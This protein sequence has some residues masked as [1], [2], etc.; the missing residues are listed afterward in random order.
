MASYCI[1]CDKEKSTNRGGFCPYCMVYTETYS[2][3]QSRIDVETYGKGL[4]KPHSKTKKMS[5]NVSRNTYSAEQSGIGTN[6]YEVG[7]KM[8][9][10]NTKKLSEDV[11]RKKSLETPLTN[12]YPGNFICDICGK[13]FANQKELEK[14]VASIRITH[15][16]YK[17]EL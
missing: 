11:S 3:E 4:K 17:I 13:R 16:R 9:N 5:K 14:H 6:T 15:L 8:L 1:R 7:L 2:A 10:K 12:G